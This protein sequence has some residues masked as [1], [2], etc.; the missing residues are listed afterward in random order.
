MKNGGLFILSPCA[1]LD[2][3]TGRRVG[4]ILKP[5]HPF[6]TLGQRLTLKGAI[7]TLRRPV[8]LK[9][10]DRLGVSFVS[11]P[12]RA[13]Y[14]VTLCYVMLRRLRDSSKVTTTRLQLKG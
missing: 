12:N 10:A 2:W 1:H 6:L 9:P 4:L 5:R 8:T 14:A 13:S 7:L 3:R 11:R